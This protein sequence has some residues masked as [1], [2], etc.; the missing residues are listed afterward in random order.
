MKKIVLKVVKQCVSTDGVE[1]K[2]VR[3]DIKDDFFNYF[4]VRSMALDKRN[5]RQLV[6][7]TVEIAIKVGGADIINSIVLDLKDNNEPYRKMVMETIEK[8][9]VTLGVADIDT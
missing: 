3:D 4:W 7:T 9:I 2:F 8:I 5:Y 1:P 6:D